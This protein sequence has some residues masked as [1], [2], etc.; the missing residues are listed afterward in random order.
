MAYKIGQIVKPINQS[1]INDYDI[2]GNPQNVIDTVSLQYGINYLNNFG[3]QA[4]PGSFFAIDNE[5]IM[6][7]RSGTYEI[8]NDLV[9]VSNLR[10]LSPGTYIIDFKY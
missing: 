9:R 8:N 6:I 4:R 1:Y 3:I 2:I 7:G 5:I 10:L